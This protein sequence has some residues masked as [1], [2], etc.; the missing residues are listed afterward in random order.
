MAIFVFVNFVTGLINSTIPL[1][2]AENDNVQKD[3][4]AD[5]SHRQPTN[6][7]DQRRKTQ[8]HNPKPNDQS[9][10]E[11]KSYDYDYQQ[12][13]KDPT[14]NTDHDSRSRH[15]YQEN[16]LGNQGHLKT[17]KDGSTTCS[18]DSD[19]NKGLFFLL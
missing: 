2:L 8:L 15:D 19:D 10:F 1:I 6:S 13:S 3:N 18:A 5:Q 11:A 7:E 16:I 14:S 4:K 17:P 9:Q 12:R